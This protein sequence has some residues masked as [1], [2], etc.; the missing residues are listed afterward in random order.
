[1]TTANLIGAEIAKIGTYQ[2]Q[3]GEFT[4]N[5]ESLTNLVD[6]SKAFIGHWNIPIKLGHNLQQLLLAEDGLPSAGWVHNLRVSEDVLLADLMHVPI[7]IVDIIN[8]KG[9]DTLSFE[10]SKDFVIGSNSYPLALIGLALLGS[11]LPAIDTL[12]DLSSLYQVAKLTTNPNAT[13]IYASRFQ[14][15][16]NTEDVMNLK[17]LIELFGLDL[18]EEA[19]EDEVRTAVKVKIASFAKE[20]ES[21]NDP[22]VEPA[23]TEPVVADPVLAA[24]RKEIDDSKA[25]ILA[26]KIAKSSNL[27]ESKV[28][29][30]I[31][32]NKFLPAQKVDL[33]KLGLNSEEA[34]DSLVKNT[35][36]NTIFAREAGTI[37]DIVTV[38]D[39]EVSQ[40]TLDIAKQMGL[41]EDYLKKGIIVANKMTEGQLVIAT[42]TKEG[43]S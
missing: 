29:A 21:T 22:V 35:P 41:S 24:M 2:G 27:I 1:M 7:Q 13:L 14:L 6:A 42:E 17:E 43:N 28:D 10:L 34:F 37:T 39:L 38:D 23:V 19:T 3:T 5:A 12:K 15:P 32:A 18:K 26:L 33:I 25:E 11:D 4:L 9:Y 40:S 30:A 36:A 8:A 16:K 20:P 31:I